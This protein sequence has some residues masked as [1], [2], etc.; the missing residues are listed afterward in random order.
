MSTR[1]IGHR[2]AAGSY[3][4]NTRV[5]ILGAIKLG[6]RWIEVDVQP[7]LD[8]QLVVCHDHKINRCSNGKGRVDSFSLSELKTFDFGTWFS[9]EFK[10]EPILTLHEL[11]IIAAEHQIG[12]N[13][14]VKVDKHQIEPIVVSLKTE[15]ER[16]LVSAE[17]LVLS[18]FSHEVMRALHRVCSDYRLGVISERYNDKTQHLLQHIGAYSCHLNYK[19]LKQAHIDALHD[20]GQ[21]VWCY[22]VNHADKFALL[23]Q[24]DAIFTDYPE[25]FTAN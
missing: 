14:E 17:N 9:H 8:G 1:I 18:S 6:V 4:E 25:R 12:L 24:V 15:L 11:L 19:N 22:T 10:D 23:P 20:N 13:I 7:S 2:G 5:S 16:G 21:Q 3:P